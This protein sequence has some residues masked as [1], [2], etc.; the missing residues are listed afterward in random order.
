MRSRR[1]IA[2]LFAAL[3][4][5]AGAGL[6]WRIADVSPSMARTAVRSRTAALRVATAAS[7]STSPAAPSS[8][9][10][11]PSATASAT[12]VPSP[13]TTTHSI[14]TGGL[15]RSWVQVD[16]GAGTP[17]GP[18]L[19]VL[20][21]R[22]VTPQIEL[23]R[24]AISSPAATAGVTLVYPAGVG[25]SWNA[26]DCCGAAYTTGV[27]DVQFLRQLVATV[28]PGHA[29]QID[30]A[31]YSNGG[32]LAYAVACQAPTLVDGIAVVNMLPD[33]GCTVTA[34]MTLLQ[35]VGTADPEAPAP[36]AATQIAALAQLDACTTSNTTQSGSLTL[37]RWDGC[38][39]GN[40]VALATYQGN[41]HSWPLGDATTPGAAQTILDFFA[42]PGS[43][44]LS[45]AR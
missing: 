43:R 25:T 11:A 17:S 6:A 9:T 36:T 37:A 33:P 32:R 21:G 22:W 29:R 2:L 1:R 20:H 30:L 27:D 42:R 16:P 3:V 18:I 24:D 7:P 12:P 4:A 19:I 10:A 5:L 39:A 38:T 26:G 13:V 31:G 41:D 28:D 45:R 44:G 40:R 34:P 8:A 15:T 35:L 23:Q 14:V